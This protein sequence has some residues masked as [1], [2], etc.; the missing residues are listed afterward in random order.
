[1]LEKNKQKNNAEKQQV[2]QST[3]IPILMIHHKPRQRELFGKHIKSNK[4]AQDLITTHPAYKLDTIQ[5]SLLKT[6]KH[7][8]PN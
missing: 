3:L 8:D 4:I 7:L 2:A 6:A 5:Y 1:M